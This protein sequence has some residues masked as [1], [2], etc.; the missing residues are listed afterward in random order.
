MANS[1]D[2]IHN[3]KHVLEMLSLLD[4]FIQNE[5]ISKDDIDFNIQ[6]PAVC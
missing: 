6:L 1:K 5:N 4:V 2:P 3:E